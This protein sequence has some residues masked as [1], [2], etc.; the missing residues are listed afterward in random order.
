M[1]QEKHKIYPM[2]DIYPIAVVTDRYWGTYSGGIWT[3]WNCRPTEIPEAIFADD[4]PCSD[5][6]STTTMI[7]GR[8]RTPED[9]I[10]DLKRRLEQE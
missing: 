3:A 4:I 10:E 1:D 9:A 5:F 2:H 8:G 6:W 7:I